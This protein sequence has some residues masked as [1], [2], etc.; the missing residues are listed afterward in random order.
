[1]KIVIATDGHQPNDRYKG[2]LLCAGALPEEVVLLKPGEALPASFDGLLLAGGAD[3]DP[4][5]YGETTSAP[6]VTIDPDR[7]DLDL[8]LFARAE[9][10]RLPVLAICRGLQVVNV[11]LGGTL[12][13]DLPTERERGT[14]HEREGD[15]AAPVHV[16]RC[17]A[18]VGSASPVAR[19]FAA[20]GELPVNSRHHQ[21]VKDLAAGL[22][23]LAASPDDLIEAFERPDPFLLAVQWHPED[24]VAQPF[25]KGLF[26][27]FLEACRAFERASGRRTAPPIEVQLEGRIPVVRIDRPARRNAFA[28]G[29]REM[30]AGTIET[31]GTD[32]TV[33][34]IVLTGAGNAFSAGADLDVLRALVEAHDEAGFGALLSAGARVVLSVARAPRPVLAAIDGPAAGAGMNLALACDVRVASA[35]ERYEAVFVQS[36]AAI[37]LSPDWGGTFHLPLLAGHGRAADLVFSGE[38]ISAV[39]AKEIG[40]VDVLV[41]D[42]PSLPIALARAA[43]YAEQSVAALAAA[44]RNLNAERL[45]RLEQAL[46]REAEAQLELF[47]SGELARLLPAPRTRAEKTETR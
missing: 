36:F 31:L 41:E 40:L 42:G 43:L 24:L 26:Q 19:D 14:R 30:L 13:Q 45:P 37:G 27:R 7:D 6:R 15:R 46:A 18:A 28:G 47:R 39:R 2:A 1:M 23:P 33:P 5:R 10:L 32:P 38:R 4:A 17:R 21:A 34:A 35:F 16:V 12:W 3:I 29:M 25:Q 11:A 8:H 22:V 9:S 44:K 20:A